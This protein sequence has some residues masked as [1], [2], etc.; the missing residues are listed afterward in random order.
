MLNKYQSHSLTDLAREL[1]QLLTVKINN[2]LKPVW[3]VV[4]N[5]EVKE[6]VS[7]QIANENGISGNIKFIFPS[8]FIWMIYRLKVSDVPKTLPT[9]LNALHW[10]LF[11]L[12]GRDQCLLDELPFISDPEITITKRFQLAGQ[13]AD[14]LDQYQVYRPGMVSDWGQG[15]TTTKHADEQWQQKIWNKL[16]AYWSENPHTQNIP[17]R[18]DAHNSVIKWL[19]DGDE[20]LISDIPMIPLYLVYHILASHLWML[21][22]EYHVIRMFTSFPEISNL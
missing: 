1:A 17:G 12:L 16:S 3:V 14:V 18:S 7:L 21:W 6:W 8:E 13:I 10:T 22:Q 20:A 19:N 4:Q 2:P 5:N 9:D 11:E 15:K